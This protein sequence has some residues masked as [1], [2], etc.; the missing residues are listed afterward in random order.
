MI[1][2][3]RKVPVKILKLEALLRRLPD[4]HIKRP[5]I[6][7]ELA[8]SKAGFRREQSIDFYLEIDPN[9]RHF[10]FMIS[11][12]ECAINFSRYIHYSSLL[13]IY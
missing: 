3:E 6:E 7:E 13:A 1:V 8:I 9:P 10:S 11:G 12:C 5:L 4:H 2:K